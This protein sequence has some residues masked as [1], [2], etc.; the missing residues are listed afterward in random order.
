[1]RIEY[2]IST[3]HYS[4]P[5]WKLNQGVGARSYKVPVVFGAQYVKKPHILVSISGFNMADYVEDV[6]NVGVR[7]VAEA[8]SITTS[9][10]D[11]VFRTWAGGRVYGVTA[12]WIAIGEEKSSKR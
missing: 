1:M 3:G 5:K 6:G 11:L 9:G 8:K 7:V 4:D 2:G 12:N 10:F